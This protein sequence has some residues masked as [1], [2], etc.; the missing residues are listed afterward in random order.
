MTEEAEEEEE[1]AEE[2]SFLPPPRPAMTFRLDIADSE[3]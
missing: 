3:A 2:R 1:E